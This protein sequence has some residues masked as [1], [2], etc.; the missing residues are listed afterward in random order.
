MVVDCDFFEDEFYVLGYCVVFVVF[1]GY[2]GDE[3]LFY[4][5]V[6][7]DFV[8]VV[9]GVGLFE[10]YELYFVEVCIYDDVGYDGWCGG[11]IW[12]GDGEG[13]WGG[14]VYGSV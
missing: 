4:Y 6:E 10:Y 1:V 9:G 12:V 5:C 7:V 3:Y 2:F 14:F 8:F 13:V 11:V